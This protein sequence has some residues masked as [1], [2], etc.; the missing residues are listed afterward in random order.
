MTSWLGSL[1]GDNNILIRNKKKQSLNQWFRF[2]LDSKLIYRMLRF[3]FD[4]WGPYIYFTSL[5]ATCVCMCWQDTLHCIAVIIWL[6]PSLLWSARPDKP[7]RIMYN[8][9]FLLISLTLTDAKLP[10]TAIQPPDLVCT[11]IYMCVAS[12]NGVHG[13]VAWVAGALLLATGD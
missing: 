11:C 8:R 4:H 1:L 12:V 7:Y 2:S 5:L 10:M 3:E 9:E 6:F 13:T